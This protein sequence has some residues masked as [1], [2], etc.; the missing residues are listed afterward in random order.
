MVER[1]QL[2]MA[3]F[4]Q[5]KDN[6]Y[7][8]DLVRNFWGYKNLTYFPNSRPT[9]VNI[10]GKDTGTA[11]EH[12]FQDLKSW[13][14]TPIMQPLRMQYTPK[15][16]PVDYF[17]FPNEPIV[18]IQNQKRIV[19]TEIDGNSGSFKE[20]YSQ[21]DYSITIKGIAVNDDPNDGEDYPEEIVRKFRTINELRHHVKV[22]GALFTIFNIEYLTITGLSLPR[23]E[24]SLGM[25]PYEFTALSDKVFDLELK[26]A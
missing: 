24:G 10:P 8:N 23:I 3:D 7:L 13:L 5:P 2:P 14:G 16:Q 20:I 1:R 11:L 21:G 19:E 18:E 26:K 6:N 15:G 9:V 17:L 4:V 12:K 22:Q 25:Q